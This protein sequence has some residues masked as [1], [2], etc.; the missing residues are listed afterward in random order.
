MT[1]SIL[2]KVHLEPVSSPVDTF[3]PRDEDHIDLGAPYQRGSVW[4]DEQRRNLIR[5]LLMGIPTGTVIVAEQP[6][7][8]ARYL[9][10][11]DGKQRIE[12]IRSFAAGSL[13]VPAAWFDDA[14]LNG[15]V[16][17]DVTFADLSAR[18]G[19][20][21]RNTP[22]PHLRFR[23]HVEMAVDPDTGRWTHR[24]R[25]TDEALAAEAVVY[26]LINFGGTPHTDDDR[27]RAATAGSR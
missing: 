22:F 16:N 10:V 17:T 8:T 13:A 18:G 5:S 27:A 1:P 25:T 4:T 11:L 6:V 2:P 14:D 7:S 3:L 20:M 9:R 26:D 15:D 24:D 19:R 12:A 21:F 23:S